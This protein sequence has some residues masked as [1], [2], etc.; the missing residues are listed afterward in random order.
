MNDDRAAASRVED[1]D[2]EQ[3]RRG[4]SPD[5]HRERIVDLE[6]PDRVLEG[7]ADVLVLDSMLTGAGLDGQRFSTVHKLACERSEF[8]RAS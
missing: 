7:V 5:Q 3:Q 6:H 1:P 4:S 8:K 2:L